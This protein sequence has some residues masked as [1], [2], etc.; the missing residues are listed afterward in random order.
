MYENP[1][2]NDREGLLKFAKA[3]NRFVITFVT[4]LLLGAGA[5]GGYRY[6]EGSGQLGL[7]AS[8]SLL[9]I[10]LLVAW[11]GAQ[12]FAFLN[13][14]F[15]CEAVYRSRSTPCAIWAAMYLIFVGTAFV[16]PEAGLIALISFIALW[17][18][19]SS[20]LRKAKAPA[21]TRIS[22]P[23][24]FETAQTIPVG[25][26]AT[27]A[28]CSTNEGPAEQDRARL[29][30][31][32][33]AFNRFVAVVILELLVGGG[34]YGWYG[35]LESSGQLETLEYRL[36][37]AIPFFLLGLGVFILAILYWVFLGMA[38]YNSQNKACVSC[39]LL[40]L[41]T[42]V[43]SVLLPQIAFLNFIMFLVLVG[44]FSA[45]LRKSGVPLSGC[46]VARKHLKALQ[47]GEPIDTTNTPGYG[48]IG[49]IFRVFILLVFFI[50]LFFSILILLAPGY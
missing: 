17:I 43:A 8:N 5:Y 41:A 19:L 28:V 20:A 27:P 10:S 37:L 11:Y 47:N 29:L 6:L 2:E 12:I 31:F 49:S 45:A 42:T 18:S 30:R 35:Y 24:G 13:V 40:H 46:F 25:G 48:C 26:Y 38:A 23:A 15:Q 16:R 36:E 7:L 33:R 9:D 21:D 34:Y 44:V 32:A 3:Y 39:T 22:Q 1:L 14:I 4:S 50:L